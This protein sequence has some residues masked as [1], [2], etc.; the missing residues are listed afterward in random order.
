V[1][2]VHGHGYKANL[3]GFLSAKALG[4]PFVATCH[5]WTGASPAIR[6]YEFLDSLILRRAHK[7]V[8][9]SDAISNTLR[10]SGLSPERVSTIHNGTDFSHYAEASPTLRTELRVGER[11][12]IGSVGR[13]ETQKGFEYFVQAA[14]E[15]IS[16]FPQALFVII[17][18]GS[19]RS[20]LEG[21]IRQLGL[22]SHVLLLGQRNDMPD[23]YASLDLFVLASIDE[24]MPMTILEA[25][26]VGKAVVATAVGAVK[27]LVI[28]EQTGL[29]VQPRDVTALRDA[30]LRCIRNPSF[31]RALERNGQKHVRDSFS[32]ETMGRRYLG[33]YKR[34][35][36]EQ[37]AGISA[38]MQAV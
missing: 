1:S 4:L 35:L 6:F 38:S 28:P 37:E 9:V 2:L 7:V 18:E 20:K 34:L 36:H 29:L 14:G 17:G 30:I 3:Y 10:K 22:E 11:I 31:T 25:L 33:L 26:S 15:V 23:V 24:G 19:L 21:L 32:A 27:E 13:L 8:G 5:L 16:E 12:L